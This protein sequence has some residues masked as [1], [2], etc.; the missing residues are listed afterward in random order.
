MSRERT[1][2]AANPGNLIDFLLK[3]QELK[4]DAA[5]SRELGV[6]PAVISKIRHGVMGVGAVF[7]LAIHEKF[8]TPVDAIR[9][10][11]AS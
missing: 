11:I 9:K 2:P 3:S 6:S 4:N 10:A 8:G 5:L 7:I 1:A